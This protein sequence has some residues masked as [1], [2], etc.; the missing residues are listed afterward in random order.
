MAEFGSEW[1]RGRGEWSG[2]VAAMEKPITLVFMDVVMGQFRHLNAHRFYSYIFSCYGLCHFSARRAK[3]LI[4]AS[5]SD[6]L[7]KSLG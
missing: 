1:L 2:A 5:M 7:R 6:S 4:E 3:A